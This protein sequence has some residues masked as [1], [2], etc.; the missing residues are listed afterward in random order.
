MLSTRGVLDALAKRE[1]D[2]PPVVSFRYGD[3]DSDH[4]K[5]HDAGDRADTDEDTTLAE[6]DGDDVGKE[7]QRK[8]KSSSSSSKKLFSV[9]GKRKK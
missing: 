6:C 5:R 4:D 9:F 1:R 8:R 3:E 2:S 7:R